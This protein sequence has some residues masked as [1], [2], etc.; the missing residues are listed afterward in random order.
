VLA[1][2]CSIGHVATT[3]Q[4]LAGGVKRSQIVRELGVGSI[5]RPRRGIFACS[6]IPALTLRAAQLGGALTCVSVLREAGVWAGDPA[7]LHVQLR[8]D[9]RSRS[10]ADARFHREYPRFEMESRARAGPAQALWR[11]IHCLDEENAIAAMESAI[12]EGF[13]PETLVREIGRLAPRR[14]TPLVA[15]LIANSGSGNETIVRLR[16]ERVGYRVVAQGAVPGLGHQDLVVEDCVGLEVD[17]RRWHG[18]DRF[19]NDRDRDLHSEGLGRRVLRLRASHI[20][21]TWTHTL[22]VIQ[23]VVDDAVRERK[24]RAGRIVVARDDRI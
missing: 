23:R 5:V 1:E 11:A 14:L 13:L 8:P 21:S 9:S 3:A 16:L 19:A 6:H 2:L 20:H 24:R 22:T 4:L 15:G 12:H 18:E 7:V 10:A 17:G